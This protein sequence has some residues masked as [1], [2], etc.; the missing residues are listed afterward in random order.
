MRLGTSGLTTVECLVALLL[1]TSG[2]LG[3]VGTVA[4]SVRLEGRGSSAAAAARW[5]LAVLD[6]L[7]G[8]AGR[9][10][11]HCAA[12]G[13]GGSTGPR[14]ASA[15]WTVLPAGRGVA[16]S[17]QLAYPTVTGPHVDSV[18]GFISCD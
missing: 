5:S 9:A 7:Q 11:G 2:L 17:L 1:A 13:S 8:V 15:R 16:L 6:S 10:G 3:A 14:G 12:I 4:L 18:L